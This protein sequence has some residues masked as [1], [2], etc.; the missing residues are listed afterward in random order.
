MI[1]D[2]EQEQLH[3]QYMYKKPQEDSVILIYGEKTVLVSMEA[4]EIAYPTYKQV[5]NA[6]LDNY[7]QNLTLYY[8][9]SIGNQDYFLLDGIRYGISFNGYSDIPLSKLRAEK[10]KREIFAAAT[11]WHLLLWYRK[12]QF[13]GCCGHKMFHHIGERM[14]GCPVCGN[15]V[16]PKIQPAVIVGVVHNDRLLLTKYA[17]R[18][19]KKYA[20]IAGFTEIGETVEE[21][22]S[23]EV[24]EEVGLRVKNIQYYKSQPW[25][26]DGDLLMGFFCE[27]EGSSEIHMDD[28]ELAFAQWMKREDIPLYTEDLSLTGEMM[29]YFRNGKM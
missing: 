24:M 22:V 4:G 13:C 2:L 27:V 28:G 23:R 14:L 5:L 17:G 20:L 11:G 16:F 10:P 26:F 7:T 21:T 19:Y 1:Q 29:N 6:G 3:N 9:F 8:G 12:N 15:M 25:G 18:A